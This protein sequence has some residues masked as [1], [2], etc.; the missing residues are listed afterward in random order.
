VRRCS[1]MF[2]QYITGGVVVVQQRGQRQAH[3]PRHK[4]IPTARQSTLTLQ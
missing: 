4:Q 2:C 1:G 3:R